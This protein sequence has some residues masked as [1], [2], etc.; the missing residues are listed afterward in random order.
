MIG[1]KAFDSNL[2]CKGFQ[3]EIGKTYEFDGDIK[4]CKAG[5][6][7]C[8]NLT[9]CFWYYSGEHVRFAKVEALGAVERSD[10]DSKCV[11]DKIRIIEEI[12][13]DEAIK[14]SNTGSRNTGNSNAGNNNTGGWNAGDRNTGDRNIGDNNTGNC[15]TGECN[16]GFSNSGGWNTGN[17]NTGN[18]N[19][20]NCNSGDNNTG[21]HNSGYWDAGDW[22]SGDWNTGYWNTGNCNTGDWNR[23][24]SNTGCFM[25]SDQTIM[26]FNKPSDW[27]IHDWRNSQAFRIMNGCLPAKY[28][29]TNWITTSNMT[30]KEKEEHP[31]YKTT[32]GYLKETECEFDRQKWWDELSDDDKHEVM[33]LPNFDADIFFECT[34]IKVE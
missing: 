24:S 21:G 26:M 16:V 18:S 31:E 15:N 28:T 23:S 8:E 14:M 2:M 34:G 17:W 11:T 30:D 13:L 25:T 5:F 10:R 4:L 20:G 6:H 32:G 19:A 9:D 33:S 27:T 29:D 3:Y 22:N 7:F 1:Y 12:S